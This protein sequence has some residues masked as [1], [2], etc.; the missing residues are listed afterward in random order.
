VILHTVNTDTKYSWYWYLI[1]LTP[2]LNTINT[3]VGCLVCSCLYVLCVFVFCGFCCLL[4]L[5]YYYATFLR[6]K[7]KCHMSSQKVAIRTNSYQHRMQVD[8]LRTSSKFWH[9]WVGVHSLQP[10][11]NLHDFHYLHY[12]NTLFT[13]V[14]L[15]EYTICIV[16]NIWVHYLHYLSTSLSNQSFHIWLSNTVGDFNC[17]LCFPLQISCVFGGHLHNW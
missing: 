17:P 12:R 3:V 15:F 5:V 13:W 7:R 4:V 1:R 6:L 9:T 2:I 11:H 10:L 8:L 16:Y 14:A